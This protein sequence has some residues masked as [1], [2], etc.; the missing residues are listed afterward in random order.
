MSGITANVAKDVYG[1]DQNQSKLIM[2]VALLHGREDP[3]D[4]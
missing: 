1:R 4:F 3:G 2:F